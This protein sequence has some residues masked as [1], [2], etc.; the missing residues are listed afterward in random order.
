MNTTERNI[1][2]L[3]YANG[4]EMKKTALAHALSLSDTALDEALAHLNE[5][6]DGHALVLI[7]TD[8]T[9][10]LR[11]AAEQDTFLRE[12]ERATLLRDVGQAGLEVLTIALYKGRVARSDIDYIRGVNS[13]QTLRHLV[14]RGLLERL[15]H[16]DDSRQWLYAV[17]PELLAHL[18]ITDVAALPDYEHIV[19]ALAAPQEEAATERAKDG[20]TQLPT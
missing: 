16:P 6:L 17:T 20:D 5:A 1:E 7:V 3:L 18:G 4:G 14:M 19:S 2:A 11:T 15:P 12:H 10:S 9:V 8:T 13:A